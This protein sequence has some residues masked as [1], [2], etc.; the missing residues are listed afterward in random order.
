VLN[1][2]VLFS[3][4]KMSDDEKETSL[5]PDEQEEIEDDQEYVIK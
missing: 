5:I 1:K 2:K 4:T 3:K